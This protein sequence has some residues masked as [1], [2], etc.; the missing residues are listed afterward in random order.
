MW[1]DTTQVILMV[2][3]SILLVSIGITVTNDIFTSF[4]IYTGSETWEFSTGFWEV[5]GLL[6]LEEKY[7]L[8]VPA[9]N[10]TIAENPN[11]WGVPSAEALHLFRDMNSGDLPWTGM[12]FGLMVS[13]IWYWCTDQVTVAIFCCFNGFI[14][15]SLNHE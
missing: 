8:A 5:G 11:C 3:G 9:R 14:I 15:I 4:F 2:L 10:Y 6:Q 12:V 7:F 13:S 1:V